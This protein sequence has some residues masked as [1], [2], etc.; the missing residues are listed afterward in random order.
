MSES[1]KIPRPTLFSIELLGLKH[2]LIDISP[3]TPFNLNDAYEN[4]FSYPQIKN[5]DF[6]K[7]L[8]I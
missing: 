3:K 2:K 6:L 1:F 7:L 5:N 4:P 8:K